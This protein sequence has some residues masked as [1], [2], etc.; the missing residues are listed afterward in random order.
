MMG[1]FYLCVQSDSQKRTKLE[2]RTKVCSALWI[3]LF[4]VK[5]DCVAQIMCMC[6]FVCTTSSKEG[7]MSAPR[8]WCSIQTTLSILSCD[9]RSS[10]CNS[11]HSPSLTLTLPLSLSH[12]L[13]LTLTLTLTHSGIW[14]HWKST[15]M[16]SLAR[17]VPYSSFT[18][19]Q[20]RSTISLWWSPSVSSKCGKT[21]STTLIDS[22]G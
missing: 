20:E 8:T 11:K 10:A 15:K 6:C 21:E 19:G 2:Q 16:R 18:A 9:F 14:F 12:S 17:L 3:M 1:V 7:S 22:S 4:D 13:T 5:W